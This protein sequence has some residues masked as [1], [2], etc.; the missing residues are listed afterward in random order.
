MRIQPRS[1]Q[2]RFV[3]AAAEPADDD[4]TAATD[5]VDVNTTATGLLMS[6]ALMPADG[7]LDFAARLRRIEPNRLIELVKLL[8][9]SVTILMNDALHMTYHSLTLRRP[10]HDLSDRNE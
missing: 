5:V 4:N 7:L 2:S 10:P 6:L 3:F 8:C 1:F 9:R